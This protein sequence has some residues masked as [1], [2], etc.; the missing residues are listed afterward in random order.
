MQLDPRKTLKNQRT[1]D[2]D[3]L[4]PTGTTG[5]QSIYS[6]YSNKLIMAFFHPYDPLF[7]AILNCSYA[8][9]ARPHSYHMWCMWCKRTGNCVLG[10]VWKTCFICDLCE[11]KSVKFNLFPCIV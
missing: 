11:G 7:V 6:E 9:Y 4:Q 2:R 8:S 3:V 5:G 1:V 10:D